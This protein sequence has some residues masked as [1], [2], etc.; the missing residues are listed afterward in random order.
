MVEYNVNLDNVFGSLADPTRR[1]ILKRV[2]EQAL[3]ISQVAEHYKMSFAAVAKHVT[4]LE[5]AKLITK[6]RKGKQQIIKA[7]PKA[8]QV[9]ADHL[10][11]YRA[12]WEDRFTAL[13]N[14]LDQSQ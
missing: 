13:E 14:Y 7:S 10:E 6:E 5:T 1:D 11:K 8:L 2:S 4:I 12:M 9:A 3:S